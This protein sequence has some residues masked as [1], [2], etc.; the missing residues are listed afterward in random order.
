M[1][2][3]AADPD[4]APDGLRRVLVGGAPAL[5]V[6]RGGTLF[7][8]GATLAEV[9]AAGRDHLHEAVDRALEGPPLDGATGSWRRSTSR[10]SGRAG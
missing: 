9:L 7:G 2:H 8:L 1:A 5:A 10:R 3:V 6:A 4:A